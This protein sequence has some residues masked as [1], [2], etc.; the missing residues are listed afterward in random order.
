MIDDAMPTDAITEV[1]LSRWDLSHE[2]KVLKEGPVRFA[3][4][5]K[6]ADHFDVHPFGISLNEAIL[7]DPQQRILLQCVA[8][9]LLDAKDLESSKLLHAGVFMV[10]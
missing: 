3:G 4:F 9:N 6:G 8:E 7:M 5:V 2:S 1:S 10:C